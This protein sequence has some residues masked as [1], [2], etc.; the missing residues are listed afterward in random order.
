MRRLLPL[1]LL[2]CLPASAQKSEGTYYPDSTGGVP[3]ISEILWQKLTDVDFVGA[4]P[5]SGGS[6]MFSG[7]FST[8]VA[9]LISAAHSH[10][11]KVNFEL[12][13]VG[14]GTNWNSA[15]TGS[16]S[17]GAMHTLIGNIQSTVNSDGFDGIFVDYEE[18]FSSQF[19][20]FMACLRT[21]FPIGT[22]KI[23]W[24]AGTN[25]QIGQVGPNN[26]VACT[27]APWPDG[28]GL[29]VAN[30]S[31]LV[32][33]SGYGLNTPGN[34]ASGETYFN[35]PLFS[36][37]GSTKPFVWSDDYAKQVATCIGISLSKVSLSIPLFGA[38]FSINTA[39][40]QTVNGSST[41]TDLY[42]STLVGLYN[43]SSA[44]YDN[45][46]KDPWLRVS[47]AGGNPA[48]YLTFE[49]AQS[50]TDKVN[51]VKTNG[52]AGWMMWTMGQDYISGGSPTMPLL[53]AFPNLTGTPPSSPAGVT[54]TVN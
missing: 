37:T 40:R 34:G 29:T 23:I 18:A 4:S 30:D 3:A 15:I 53:N 32:V 10:N 9:P 24:Y 35:S 17:A 44:T 31:D 47:A 42:Y 14:S 41:E 16:C 12:G 45:S 22:K 1:L 43:L 13:D 50:I 51:Y 5:Q 39:P 19:P 25:Y 8:D 38:V 7:S 28:V 48:G 49:N 33:M 21:T 20:T 11:V 2:W 6:L 27:G 36:E 26:T 46:A 54:V 52:L